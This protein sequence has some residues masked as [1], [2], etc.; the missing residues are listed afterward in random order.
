MCA[1][2]PAFANIFL[3]VLVNSPFGRTA[4]RHLFSSR[5][6]FFVACASV[7]TR[8]EGWDVSLAV[9][10]ALAKERGECAVVESR[11]YLRRCGGGCVYMCARGSLNGLD[12]LTYLQ[13]L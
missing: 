2:K 6:C 10:V 9:R 11:L 7:R 13:R 3:F 8:V 4:G 1:R 5:V 12:A